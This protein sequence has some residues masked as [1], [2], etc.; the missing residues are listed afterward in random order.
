M[1]DSTEED[2][3]DAKR[4]SQ[5]WHALRELG[6]RWLVG[7]IA[8]LI[9]LSGSTSAGVAVWAA[10]RADINAVSQ[11]ASAIRGLRD[12]LATAIEQTG[13][14]D[15]AQ[16]RM[17]ADMRMDIDSIGDRFGMIISSQE[18]LVARMDRLL[19]RMD[20]NSADACDILYREDSP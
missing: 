14:V 19:C 9:V 16:D 18:E 15:D 5:I 2:T 13:D 6:F 7:G 10:S 17:I 12:T 1:M 4:G 8:S 3:V 20:G 11:N